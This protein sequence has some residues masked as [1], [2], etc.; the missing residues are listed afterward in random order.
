M[1]CVLFLVAASASATTIVMPSDEQLIAKTPL[2][3]AGTVVS[4]TPVESDGRIW[5]EATVSVARVL[6]GAAAET[7]T[8]REI[9]G[10]VNGRFTVIFG[11]PELRA[12]ERVLLFLEPSPHGGYRTIDLFAGKFS[13]ARAING[14]RLWL[15]DDVGAPVTL[16]DARLEPLEAK[17]VQRDANGFE[18]FVHERVAGRAGVKS[19][20]IENP[21]LAKEEAAAERGMR[22]N[23][24]LLSAGRIYRWSQFDNST[25]AR[26][27]VGGTQSGYSGGGITETQAGMAPWTNYSAAKI[28]YSYAGTRSG[29]FGGLS[30]GNGVNEVLLGDP[31]NEITGTFTPSTGGVVG[32]GGFN[33]VSGGG[34]W[35]APFAA[36]PSHPAG[37]QFAY[38]IT[39]GNLTIQDGVSPSAG[40][41]SNRLAEIIAH[42]FGHTLGF[43]HSSD[44]TALMYA[45]VT[46]LGPGLK[47]DDQT[48]ARWLYPNG[49]VTPGPTP[50]IPAAPSGLTASASGSGVSLA[51]SDNASDE[52]GQS[53]YLSIGGAAFTRVADVG[54]NARSATLSGLASGSYRAYVVAV[55]SA[56]TSSPSNT[57]SFTIGSAPVASFSYTPQVGTAGVTTFTFYDES[58]GTIASRSWHF[59]DGATSTA[60]VATHRYASP[61]RYTVTLTVGGAGTTSQ[62]TSTVTVAGPLTAAYSFSPASPTTNDT[63]A[64]TDQSTGGVTSWSWSF[65]DGSTST[66]QNPSRRYAQ[67]GTYAATLTVNR[68]SESTSHTKTIVVAAP[69]PTVPPVAASFDVAPSAVAVG[70]NVTFT[71]RSSGS[72]TR[73]S[74]SFGDGATSTAANP[75]H[76]Y[77]APGTYQVTLTASNATSSSTASR[78]VV[79]APLAPYR[80]LLSAAAQ[81]NGLGGTVWRTELTLFNAGPQGA[82]VTLLFLPGAGGTMLTRSLFL[83]PR[84][85]STYA[86]ALLDLFGLGNAGGALAIEATSAGAST[87]LRITS[88]TFTTGSTGTYGQ[89]VPDVQ[90]DGLAQTLYLTGIHA[91]QALRTNIGLVN[92]GANSVATTLTLF[93]R[94]GGSVATANVT[95]PANSFQ[96][97]SLATYFPSIAGRDHDV[98][99]MRVSAAAAEVSAYASVIDNVSQDPV[100]V[101][102]VPSRAGNLVTV[103][104]VGRTPGENGTFWRSDVVAFNPNS[105]RLFLTLKYRGTTRSLSIGGRETALLADVLSQ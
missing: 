75:V 100:Y 74:W 21:V 33:G 35:N 46:G 30:R 64:F 31:L 45:S 82:N 104:V 40:M 89:A 67:P 26:W 85:S 20:G 96:Q 42:E 86:N 52:S 5:T 36:D 76:A 13:E 105:D 92:R 91:N 37:T 39:E 57:A 88:R 50:T 3:V 8:I 14:K 25:P 94:D 68:N 34:N 70:N 49:T 27:F 32:T 53:V 65:G 61:G 47:S 79:V 54:A 29:S 72:P 60:S 24:T 84:Q 23:F 38:T 28:F 15:R 44:P 1:T 58:R 71:D 69:A 98:L 43:G 55:N 48:A 103:P 17:N 4:T 2:I 101:Q 95:I 12:G 6:K 90:S 11:A 93:A 62:A 63:I 78:Q 41:S 81:T 59:G 73:W 9:G 51:W 77:A 10:E 7:I 16:L 66:Q 102:A 97:A 99:S 83:A 19:Y 18:K 80:S 87:Q 56:G 22:E